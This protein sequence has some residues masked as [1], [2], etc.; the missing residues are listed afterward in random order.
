MARMNVL[1]CLVFANFTPSF[2]NF[3]HNFSPWGGELELEK[4][5]GLLTCLLVGGT[6]VP[7]PWA[8]ASHSVRA[9]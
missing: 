8:L 6:I 5:L 3:M 4:L 9:E 7:W 2:L 1:V